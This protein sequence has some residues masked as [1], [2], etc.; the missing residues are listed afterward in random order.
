MFAYP[1]RL[2]AFRYLRSR[3][4]EGFVSIIALFSILGI[5]LGVATLILVTSLMNGIRLE[6]MNNFVGIDGHV[7]VYGQGRSLTGTMPLM[8][9]IA[10]IDGVATVSQRIEGQVMASASGRALGAQVIGT[11]AE[12]IAKKPR[13][14]EKIYTQVM[15]NFKE[16]EGVLIGE[17]LLE[18]LGLSVG[19]SL[20]LISPQ[21]R[22]TFAGMVP[23]LKAY[24]I[25]GTFKLGMHAMDASLILMPY[26]DAR[27]YFTLPE[28]E[29]GSA[30]AIEITADKLEEAQ[31][32][33]EKIA[34]AIGPGYRVYDW[35]QSNQ[36][37]FNA[38]KIQRD[39]M[40][41]ILALIIL[42]AAFNIISSLIMLVKD[43]RRDIAILRAMGASRRVVLKIFL[44]TGMS[45]GIIGTLLGFGLGLLAAENLEALRQ[46]LEAALGYKILIENLYFL[47][48]LPT[49]TDPIEVISILALSLLLSFLAALYPAWRAASQPPAEVLRYE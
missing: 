47:S 1:E 40:V 9:K 38:L 18:N 43:K 44:L 48:T 45:I 21:G 4:R 30:S 15:A 11:T 6:M 8:E 23:R 32:V 7:T 12:D 29:N 27:V 25:I 17:R 26:E 49:K 35:Q 34:G 14:N 37:I 28:V 31:A 19:Q 39:V 20:T 5:M 41:I 10:H 13:L 33:A 46:W 36:G 24:K 3:R 2:L 42:V 16:G 22:A